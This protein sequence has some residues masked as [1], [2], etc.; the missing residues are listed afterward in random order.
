[1][2]RTS[3]PKHRTGIDDLADISAQG[4]EAS[5]CVA[6]DGS[7]RLKYALSILLEAWELGLLHSGVDPDSVGFDRLK[8]L[9]FWRFTLRP[10]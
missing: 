9:Q 10:K 5:I 1:M 6:A 3:K 7:T 8:R 4:Q 2:V